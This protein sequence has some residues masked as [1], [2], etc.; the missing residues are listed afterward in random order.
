MEGTRKLALLARNF[1]KANYPAPISDQVA[2]MTLEH[3]TQMAN[4]LTR[5]G[6]EARIAQQEGKAIELDSEPVVSYMLFVEEATLR[7]PI[8]P[9]ST[10]AKTFPER[11]PR[12]RRGRSLRDF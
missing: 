2:L 9:V 7:E 12:D 5:L 6:W 10:F 4:L 8:V 1:D 11:G 3:Q